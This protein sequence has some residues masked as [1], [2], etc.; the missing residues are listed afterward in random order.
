MKKVVSLILV[1]LMC[2]SLVACMS[3]AEIV[4]DFVETNYDALVENM[5]AQFSD[6]QTGSADIKAVGTTFEITLKFDQYD[7]TKLSE[8]DKTTLQ[9]TLD[10]SQS[11][12]DSMLASW[13]EELPELTGFTYKV[14]DKNGVELAAITAGTTQAD[15]AQ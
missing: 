2:L 10:A 9:S 11:T 4:A 6:Q 15:S 3:D 1:G 13:Q 12:Y 5:N 7:A 8:A 14:C